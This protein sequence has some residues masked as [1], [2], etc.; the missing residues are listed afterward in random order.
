[1]D[2][3]G[4][5]LA[6]A[7]FSLTTPKL[8][9]SS[10]TTE[11]G[12]ND[13]KGFIQLLQGAFLGIRNP[14]AHSLATD[15]TEV[16]AAQHLVFASLLARRVRAADLRAR[17]PVLGI[18][19]EALDVEP[20]ALGRLTGEALGLSSSALGAGSLLGP[21]AR[22]SHKF[23]SDLWPIVQCCGIEVRTVRPRHGA[24]FFVEGHRV[25]HVWILKRPEKLPL[26]NRPEIDT[27]LRAVL[28]AQRQGVR[29]NDL[30]SFNSMNGVVHGAPG[31][32]VAEQS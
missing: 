20:E 21:M 18:R 30:E 11:S 13:Q 23:I 1:M 4:A 5:D 17:D 3:D 2:K 29:P 22:H 26:Q 27:L 7:A 8:V 15:L 6:A 25:E 14:K 12:R 24:D 32:I 10:L 19:V 9:L 16:S 28:K 31:S